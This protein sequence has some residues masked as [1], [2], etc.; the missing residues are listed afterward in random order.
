MRLIFSAGDCNGIGIE[1]LIKALRELSASPR[2]LTLCMDTT[3]SIAVHPDTFAEYAAHLGLEIERWRSNGIDGFTI[4]SLDCEVFPCATR[5]AVRFGE[6]TPDAGA[7]AIEALEIAACEV[8]A[9][10][11]DAVVT[12]P[13]SKHSLQSVGFPFPGQTEFFAD[14]AG[15]TAPMMILCTTTPTPESPLH[16][17]RVGLATI[18]I[19]LKDVAGAISAE[20]VLERLNILHATVKNDFGCAKPRLAVLGLNPHAGEQG[21]IGREELEHIIP[22]VRQAQECGIHAEGPFPADGFFAHGAYKNY[23]GILA[24][25][26]DQG[27]IPLKLIAGGA[28]VNYSAGLPIVRTSPDHGTGYAIA[29]RGVADASSVMEAIEMAYLIVAN[30]QKSTANR[31]SIAKNLL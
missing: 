4:G 19:P 30:R 31:L 16:A 20:Q 15:A 8:I 9:G 21:H 5:A 22:A 7:M 26:H 28:G 1:V 6:T 13:V 29:G 24:M 23:D 18:H 12:M 10:R 17:L 25:Y 2:H 11:A 3:F 14:R 27:L